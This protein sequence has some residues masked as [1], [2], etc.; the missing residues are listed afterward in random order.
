MK[1]T[2]ERKNAALWIVDVQ[3]KLFPLCDHHHEVLQKM[4]LAIRG[5]QL[6]KIPCLATEQYPQGLGPTLASLKKLLPSNQTIGTKTTFSGFADP[7]CRLLAEKIGAK[8]WILLGIEAH[9]CVLQTAKDLILAGKEVIV[10]SDAITSRVAS[11]VAI[12][13]DE[14]RAFGG[15]ISST[16]TLLF[17]ILGDALSSEG[18]SLFELIKH[19]ASL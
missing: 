5:V 19:G 10:L 13:L 18:K 11:E 7:S 4:A 6:F 14:M 3:E 15:R 17:E 9:I 8:Q 2:I 12:A 1:H 16:E